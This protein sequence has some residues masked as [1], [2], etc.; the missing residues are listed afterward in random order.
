[1]TVHAHHGSCDN[2]SDND[3]IFSSMNSFELSN[4][5]IKLEHVGT[6]FQQTLAT[7]KMDA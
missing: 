5:A 2:S 1:M 7:V 3:V 4:V 6:G